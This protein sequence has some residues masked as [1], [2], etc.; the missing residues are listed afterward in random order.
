MWS[1]IATA[2]PGRSFR[3][4]ASSRRRYGPRPSPSAKTAAPGS[5][6]EY[7]WGGWAGTYFWVD[8]KEKL[9]AIFMI[10]AP[11]QQPYYP[12]LIRM[13]VDQAVVD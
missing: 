11:S 1:W 9:I 12:G 6:G 5:P 7:S 4:D 3:S 2:P 13:M 10:Q 8:P